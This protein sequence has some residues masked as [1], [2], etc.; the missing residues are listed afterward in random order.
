MV[1]YTVLKRETIS[2]LRE[3]QTPNYA[4]ALILDD[5]EGTV[6]V[7]SPMFYHFPWLEDLVEERPSDEW[8]KWAQLA[9]DVP[10]D[11]A[12]A[13]EVRC[14]EGGNSTWYLKVELIARLIKGDGGEAR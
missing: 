5:I 9:L 12:A 14:P 11:I 6:R 10:D 2:A 13:H 7:P 4:E 8:Q 1:L 3:G